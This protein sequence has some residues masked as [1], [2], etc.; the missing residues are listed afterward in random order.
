[1]AAGRAMKTA[2][3]S[4]CRTRACNRLPLC[5]RPRRQHNRKQ[6]RLSG[7]TAQALLGTGTFGRC[8][9]STPAAEY[10]SGAR[11]PRLPSKSAGHFAGRPGEQEPVPVHAAVP[12]FALGEAVSAFNNLVRQLLPATITANF[13]GTA[14]VFESSIRNLGLLLVVAILVIYIVL[15]MPCCRP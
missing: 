11:D 2:T 8:D 14:Q 10:G 5:G 7:H 4:N 9:H 1:M 3:T 13:Q 15:G 6:Q 12:G